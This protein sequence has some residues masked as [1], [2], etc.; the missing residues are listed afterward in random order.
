M[1]HGIYNM[2]GPDG[3]WEHGHP[4]CLECLKYHEHIKAIIAGRDNLR[5]AL[6]MLVLLVENDSTLPESARNGVGEEIGAPDEGVTKAMEIIQ[7]AIDALEATEPAKGA[8]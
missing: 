2:T 3:F 7:E 6:R 1:P 8:A 4:P 5:E